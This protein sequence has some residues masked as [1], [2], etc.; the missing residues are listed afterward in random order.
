MEFLPLSPPRPLPVLLTKP[1]TGQ[2]LAE[3]FWERNAREKERRRHRRRM[4]RLREGD[5]YRRQ[6]HCADEIQEWTCLI[7]TLTLLCLFFVF[8]FAI[9]PNLERR[10]YE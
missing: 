8:M 6:R 2:Q 9:V 4:R 1:L 3:V 10:E 7:L 5:S